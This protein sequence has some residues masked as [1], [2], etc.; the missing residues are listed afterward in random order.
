MRQ[1]SDAHSH[2]KAVSSKLSRTAQ[3]VQRM[4]K[5]LGREIRLVRKGIDFHVV[6]QASPEDMGSRKRRHR[7]AHHRH[8]TLPPLMNAATLSAVQG[9]L[10]AILDRHAKARSVLP[11]LALL[12]RALR[13]PDGRGLECLPFDAL[14]DAHTQLR[15]LMGESPSQPMLD[16]LGSIDDVIRRVYP[17]CRADVRAKSSLAQ[18]Q[19]EEASLSAFVELERQWEHA[20]ENA[21]KAAP[22]SD[23]APAQGSV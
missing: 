13:K 18:I 19:I 21:R 8:G 10:T 16:L 22:S 6:L 3:L 5:L 9:A 2:G 4:R 1:I 15:R 7:F 14:N 12:E 23:L 17:G 11:S 20:L